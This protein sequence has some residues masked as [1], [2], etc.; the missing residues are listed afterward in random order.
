MNIFGGIFIMVHNSQEAESLLKASGQYSGGQIVT[1]RSEEQADCDKG[2]GT[3]K[4]AEP[5]ERFIYISETAVKN[6]VADIVERSLATAAKGTAS[7]LKNCIQQE[8]NRGNLT[9]QNISSRRLYRELKKHFHITYKYR[10]F[11]NARH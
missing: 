11:V 8:E 4:A 6:N 9:T 1:N 10:N 3:G 7:E 5:P 2:E